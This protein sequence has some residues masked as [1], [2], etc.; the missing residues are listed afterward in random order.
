MKRLIQAL[1]WAGVLAGF[2]FLVSCEPLENETISEIERITLEKI[3]QLRQTSGVQLLSCNDTLCQV[4]RAHSI[5]MGERDYFEH[6]TPEGVTFDQ[7]IS[8]AGLEFSMA[9]ENIFWTSADTLGSSAEELAQSA[10]DAWWNSPGHQAIMLKA[11]FNQA[12]VGCFQA[13][14]RLYF[15]LDV[16]KS[17]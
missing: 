10:V 6:T 9:G 11:E 8:S 5:D 15:T 12:G 2:F 3:N 16:I 14:S 1:A 4:A 7:R 17:P 13:P